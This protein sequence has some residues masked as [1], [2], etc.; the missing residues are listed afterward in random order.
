MFDT[1]QNDLT[2]PYMNWLGEHN[3]AVRHTLRRLEFDYLYNGILQHSD[4]KYSERFYTNTLQ[5]S[6]ITCYGSMH[7]Y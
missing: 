3:Q 5:A 4:K 2:T 1:S 6:L 7:T